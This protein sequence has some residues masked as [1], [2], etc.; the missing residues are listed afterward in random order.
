VGL[1]Q[2]ASH[3]SG[4]ASPGRAH[5]VSRIEEE[6]SLV[7][8]VARRLKD[9][10]MR[11]GTCR[12]RRAGSGRARTTGDDGRAVSE[13]ALLSVLDR[14]HKDKAWGGACRAPPSWASG[15]LGALGARRRS[16]WGPQG[17]GLGP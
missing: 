14:M 8:A 2:L 7:L 10:S 1:G 5:G 4:T 3:R 12:A 13:A 16:L 17:V 11:S 6:W 9:R 15:A